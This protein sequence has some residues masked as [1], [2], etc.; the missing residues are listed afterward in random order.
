MDGWW[1]DGQASRGWR[2]SEI[3]E[4]FLLFKIEETRGQGVERPAVH[5]GIEIIQ[6]CGI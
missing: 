2:V 6:D 5:V 4:E 3:K 1:V